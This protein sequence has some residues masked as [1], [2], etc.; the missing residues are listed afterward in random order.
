MSNSNIG[1][2]KGRNIKDHLFLIYGIINS[3]IRGDMPCIDLQIYDL[4]K[5]FD[6]LWLEDCMLDAYDSL[7]KESRDDKI[8]LLYDQKKENLVAKKLPWD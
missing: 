5:A 3:V 2:L 7:E 8:S 1:A 4:V 6:S